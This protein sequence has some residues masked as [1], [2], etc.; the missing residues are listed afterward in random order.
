[1]TVTRSY[2]RGAHV[3][4][5]VFSLAD[6]YSFQSVKRWYADIQTSAPAGVVVHLVGNKSDEAEKRQVT[7]TEAQ[8]LAQELKI[9]YFETSAK[10]GAGVQSAF[11]VASSAALRKIA[12]AADT[13]L[14]LQAGRPAPQPQ[15]SKGWI[16]SAFSRIAGLFT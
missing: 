11:L 6:R 2:Y 10:S 13:A 16:S 8:E 3:V 14:D 5:I 4:L 9:K 15:A 12:Q 7:E 1:M